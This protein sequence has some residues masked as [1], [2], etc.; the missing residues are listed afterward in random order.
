MK[1][2]WHLLTVTLPYKKGTWNIIPKSDGQEGDEGEVEAVEIGPPVFDVP[3]DDG[4]EDHED[5]ET[6][7][8]VC[9]NLAAKYRK[10]FKISTALGNLPCDLWKLNGKREYLRKKKHVFFLRNLNIKC[11]FVRTSFSSFCSFKY[12][13]TWNV[14]LIDKRL[15]IWYSWTMKKQDKNRISFKCN[16]YMTKFLMEVV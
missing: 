15:R 9:E 8:Q 16:N 5:D 13:Q 12:V 14:Y 10:M 2:N 6:R 1:W 4:G 11:T 3:K 7:K